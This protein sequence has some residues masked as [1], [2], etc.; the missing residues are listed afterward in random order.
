MLA[1]ARAPLAVPAAVTLVCAGSGVAG[2]TAADAVRNNAAVTAISPGNG[3]VVGIAH[4]VMVEFAAPVRYRLA[5][6]RAM[7]I[8][9][10]SE[11]SGRFTWMS[12][13]VMQWSRPPSGLPTPR[14]R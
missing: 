7:T 9:T 4:P 11:V 14:S 5:A 12:D 3:Q 6:Q 8:E 2:A 1:I 10:P 13:R